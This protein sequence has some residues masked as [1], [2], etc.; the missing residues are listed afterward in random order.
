MLQR[1]ESCREPGS[2]FAVRRGGG[3]SL[4]GPSLDDDMIVEQGA[5]QIIQLNSATGKSIERVGGGQ[6][7]MNTLLRLLAPAK[8]QSKGCKQL[9]LLV[10]LSPPAVRGWH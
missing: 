4:L 1:A 9:D 5:L 3:S 10:H 7:I 2:S 8:S 6:E